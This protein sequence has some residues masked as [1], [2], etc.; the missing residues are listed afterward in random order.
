M[1]RQRNILNDEGK[2]AVQKRLRNLLA[3][4]FQKLFANEISM[5]TCLID[6][7]SQADT[8]IHT[9][10]KAESRTRRKKQQQWQQQHHHHVTQIQMRYT[11]QTSDA[12]TSFWQS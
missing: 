7:L 4:N 2:Y 9:L 12:K 6:A 11:L 1:Y 8:H 5:H 3:S 10:S